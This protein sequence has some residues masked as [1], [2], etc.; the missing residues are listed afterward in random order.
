MV[1]VP[2]SIWMYCY[3]LVTQIKIL[4]WRQVCRKQQGRLTRKDHRWW[5]KMCT[6]QWIELSNNFIAFTTIERQ[7]YLSILDWLCNIF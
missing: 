3:L 7:V 2:V 6:S 5:T 4:S 1:A